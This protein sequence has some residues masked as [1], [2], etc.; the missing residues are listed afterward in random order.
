MVP[1]ASSGPAIMGGV[2]AGALVLLA[3][4]LRSDAGPDADEERPPEEP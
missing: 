4:L 1:I 2:I 3:V